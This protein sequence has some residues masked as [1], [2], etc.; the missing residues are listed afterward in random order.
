MSRYDKIEDGYFDDASME[1][2]ERNLWAAVVL[3]ALSDAKST[4]PDTRARVARWV[5]GYDFRVVC[6]YAG[7]DDEITAEKFRAVLSSRKAPSHQRT[8]ARIERD[9][10]ILELLDEGFGV[11]RIADEL[12]LARATVSNTK[13]RHGPAK[14]VPPEPQETPPCQ[15][16]TP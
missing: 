7:V 5:G 14:I 6:G 3:S 13:R 8:L 2:P 9:K 15:P 12:G 11:T 10:R 4:N 16:S 1:T